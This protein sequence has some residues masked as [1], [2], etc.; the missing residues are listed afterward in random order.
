MGRET[1]STNTHRSTDHGTETS[2]GTGGSF[3]PPVYQVA[4]LPGFIP[5][6]TIVFFA[7]N[8]PHIQF[9]NRFKRFI[10]A[11]KPG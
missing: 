5:C 2:A 1:L 9:M 3:I 8:K 11:P 10:I 4:V 7:S 6:H